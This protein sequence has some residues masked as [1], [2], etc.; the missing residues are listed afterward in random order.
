MVLRWFLHNVIFQKCHPIFFLYSKPK[1]FANRTLFIL[2]L[3]LYAICEWNTMMTSSNEN[4]FRVTGHYAG[5]SPVPGEFLSQRPVM[6]N[7]DAF[8]DLHLNKRLSKKSRRWW[9]Q[10]PSRPLWRHSSA[11]P[12]GSYVTRI[13]VGR[14]EKIFKQKIKMKHEIEST[15]IDMWICH[16]FLTVM[17]KFHFQF[18]K[19]CIGTQSGYICWM[20]SYVKTKMWHELHVFIRNMCS[21]QPN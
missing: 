21:L 1:C 6:R 20:I 4:I 18:W 2:W 17:L 9:F 11:A 16:M 15:M 13:M 5:N 8:F 7:F 12:W 14:N 19:Y 10:T 3:L